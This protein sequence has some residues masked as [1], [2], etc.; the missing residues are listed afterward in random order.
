MNL[1]EIIHEKVKLFLFKNL[2]NFDSVNLTRNSIEI[3]Q[4]GVVVKVIK[5]IDVENEVG[6]YWSIKDFEDMAKSLKGKEWENFYDKSKF[7]LALKM[8]IEKYDAEEGINWFI[9]Q[10]YLNELCLW[11]Q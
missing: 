10:Y 3:L 9:I 1:I 2:R 11:K 4:G 7:P 5:F 6:I 8:M